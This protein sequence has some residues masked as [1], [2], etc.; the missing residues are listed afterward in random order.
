MFQIRANRFANLGPQYAQYASD[1]K[2]IASS[3]RVLIFSSS[4]NRA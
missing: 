3:E 1:A 2:Q 4:P